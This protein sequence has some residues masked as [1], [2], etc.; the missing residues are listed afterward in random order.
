MRESCFATL[1]TLA[2][3][4]TTNSQKDQS[5]HAHSSVQTSGETVEN[6]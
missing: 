1:P 4:V 6:Q 5:S 2:Q 3:L